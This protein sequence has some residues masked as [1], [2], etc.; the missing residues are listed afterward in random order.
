[1]TSKIKSKREE[2]LFEKQ[3]K[4]MDR[5]SKRIEFDLLVKESEEK[6]NINT[7]S[8]DKKNHL[9]QELQYIYGK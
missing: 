2:R 6:K 1:M 9:N 8:Q 7:D 3:S 4:I 5:M